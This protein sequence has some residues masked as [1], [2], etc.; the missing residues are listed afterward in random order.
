MHPSLDIEWQVAFAH[1]RLIRVTRSGEEGADGD[2]VAYGEERS[3]LTC[4]DS[5]C[6][7]N[8]GRCP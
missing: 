1:H 3:D 6:D 2:T 8:D 5:Y 7:T 4:G